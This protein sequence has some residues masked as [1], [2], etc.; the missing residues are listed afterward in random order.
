MSPP[1]EVCHLSIY[2]STHH[3]PP[4][5]SSASIYWG[6]KIIWASYSKYY[7]RIKNKRQHFFSLLRTFRLVE[8]EKNLL[9][10][11]LSKKNSWKKWLWVWV[12][13]RNSVSSGGKRNI[14]GGIWGSSA[15]AVSILGRFSLFSTWEG[16]LFPFVISKDAWF[17]R[18]KGQASL[19]DDHS[20]YQ[21]KNIVFLWFEVTIE[22]LQKEYSLKSSL[23]RPFWGE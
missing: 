12:I 17:P 19:L 23:G 18:S 8:K 22:M 7:Y 16:G 10:M 14:S 6:L 5:C 1:C 3:Q 4:T 21:S 11:T 15:T 13:Q 9:S 20:F 2:S